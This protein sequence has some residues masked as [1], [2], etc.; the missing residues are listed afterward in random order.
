MKISTQEP[1]STPELHLRIFFRSWRKDTAHKIIKSGII[2]LLTVT[3]SL[4][5]PNNITTG[6]INTCS[7]NI[8]AVNRPVFNVLV[9][10]ILGNSAVF[11]H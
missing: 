7:I 3:N 11:P 4:K 6:C 2:V 9:A 1:P 10:M 5:S 8:V